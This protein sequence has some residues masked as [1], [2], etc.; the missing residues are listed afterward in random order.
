MFF[1]GANLSQGV[2][3]TWSNKLACL[4]AEKLSAMVFTMLVS[5]VDYLTELDRPICLALFLLYTQ[6]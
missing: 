4:A 5:Q 6:D 2:M 1:L 3:H